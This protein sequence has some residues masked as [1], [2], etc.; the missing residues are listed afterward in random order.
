MSTFGCFCDCNGTSLVLNMVNCIN[1]TVSFCKDLACNSTIKVN[2]FRK[3]AKI[4]K[5]D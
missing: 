1:C 4:D 3:F 2:C 5:R